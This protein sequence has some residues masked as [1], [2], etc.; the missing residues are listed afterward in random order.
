MRL[1]HWALG[2]VQIVTALRRLHIVALACLIAGA[3]AGLQFLDR[4]RYLSMEAPLAS[5]AGACWFMA[6][7]LSL[8]DSRAKPPPRTVEW[9]SFLNLYAAFL[10]AY[11]VL[12]TG[13]STSLPANTT[14]WRSWG[15]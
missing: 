4:D 6:A 12:A 14:V 11:A 5:S 10:T 15:L 13:W 9:Q 2:Q 1:H 8:C 7:A 3:V